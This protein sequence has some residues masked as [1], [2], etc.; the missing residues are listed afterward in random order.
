[1]LRCGLCALLAALLGASCR[2][3]SDPVSSACAEGLT[4]DGG[5]TDAGPTADAGDAGPDDDTGQHDAG[6][7]LGD[8]GPST[9]ADAGICGS[10]QA[11]V[12]C[13]HVQ[14]PAVV[15]VAGLA[16]S[17]LHPRAFYLHNGPPD[18]PRFFAMDDTGADLG[19]YK[20]TGGANIAWA[21]L[22]VGP[23]PTGSCVF[24]AD[25]GDARQVR[26]QY[27][28]YR[29]A[30]PA[31]LAAGDTSVTA[32]AFPFAYPDGSHDAAT[33][34]VHPLTGVLTVVTRDNDGVGT[35]AY[36]LPKATPGQPVTATPRGLVGHLG[37]DE[38]VTGGSAAPDGS[39]VL[40]R[41]TATLGVLLFAES[42]ADTATP[43]LAAAFQSTPCQGPVARQ[44]DG[45]AI[46]W[47]ESGGGYLTVDRGAAPALSYVFCA[48]RR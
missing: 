42:P 27:T 16:A 29:V 47:M 40:L 9:D 25:V 10:C 32:D 21:D 48:A 7:A 17:K 24:L 18:L 39:A 33:L 26:G 38:A 30:E 4:P 14:S 8:A 28:I 37:L 35:R 19:T 13:G 22:A 34:L 43:P 15:A 12:T 11:P 5:V 20:V 36:E 45:E 46:A 44:S 23:C 41:T 31:T 6:S 2:F 3:A 1:M